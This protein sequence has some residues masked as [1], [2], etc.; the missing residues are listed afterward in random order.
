[1]TGQF[2]WSNLSHESPSIA[3]GHAVGKE[4]L[5]H[6]QTLNSGQLKKEGHVHISIGGWAGGS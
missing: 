4:G 3:F 6:R 1:M 5:T 2:W